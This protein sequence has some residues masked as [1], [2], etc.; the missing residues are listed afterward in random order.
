MCLDAG[1]WLGQRRYLPPRVQGLKGE[2]T[3]RDSEVT[4]PYSSLCLWLSLRRGDQTKIHVNKCIMSGKERALVF[5]SVQ[6]RQTPNWLQRNHTGNRIVPGVT[7]RWHSWAARAV[8]LWASPKAVLCLQLSAGNSAACVSC[9]DVETPPWKVS[10]Q[11]I[12][13]VV[14][15]YQN[16]L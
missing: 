13:S 7:N 3:E 6:L 2:S 10:D 9:R 8:N 1:T 4:C 12:P 11:Q 15:P 16:H 14:L 5:P